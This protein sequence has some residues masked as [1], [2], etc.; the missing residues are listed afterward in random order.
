MPRAEAWRNFVVQLITDNARLAVSAHMMYAH[1]TG[2]FHSHALSFPGTKRPHSEHAW[3][4]PY[5][6]YKVGQKTYKVGQKSEFFWPTLYG[7][8]VAEDESSWKRK[9]PG[10]FATGNE[11]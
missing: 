9:L 10:T 2:T 6:T 3:N 11:R 7:A 5:N 8:K 1:G 4:R